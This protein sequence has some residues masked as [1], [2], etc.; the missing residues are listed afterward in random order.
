M[1]RVV[2]DIENAVE[3]VVS[4][5]A[6][7]VEAA[8][9]G[10]SFAVR[11]VQ[12]LHLQRCRPNVER[13]REKTRGRVSGLDAHYC[14]AVLC[15]AERRSH[16]VVIRTQ[17]RIERLHRRERHVYRLRPQRPQQPRPVIERI[18]CR[19]LREREIFLPC[20]GLHAGCLHAKNGLFDML[21]LCSRWRRRSL[22]R[23]RSQARSPAGIRPYG[24]GGT[25]RPC[26]THTRPRRRRCGWARRPNAGRA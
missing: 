26:R 10:Q 21:S 3:D 5:C 2:L 18:V 11:Q 23:H 9:A 8:R 17:S 15:G 22:P 7:P 4:E 20:K 13:Q 16:A 19:G 14:P 25:C 12:Q 1:R 6:L 24:A